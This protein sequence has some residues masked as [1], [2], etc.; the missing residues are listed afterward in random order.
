MAER[1]FIFAITGGSG[2]GKTTFAQKILSI[3]GENRCGLLSQDSYYLDQSPPFTENSGGI[4]FDHPDCLEFSLLASNLGDLR[5]GRSVRV[6]VFDRA[7]HTRRQALEYF[8]PK[9]VVL[10]D[11]ILLLSQ[12]KVRLHLDAS[13]FLEVPEA[14]RFER[15]L[16][17]DVAERGRTPESVKKQWDL[18][19]QPMHERFVEPSKVHATWIARDDDALSECIKEARLLAGV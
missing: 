4:N 1:P 3:L 18:Q 2:S 8:P 15:R 13:I 12:P 6:P 10:V 7:T 9:P 14:L 19:V 17:R 16:R 11:G 5:E